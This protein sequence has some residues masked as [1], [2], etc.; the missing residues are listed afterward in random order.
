M[1]EPRP[2][3]SVPAVSSCLESPLVEIAF[4]S[5][6]R[7]DLS[8]SPYVIVGPNAAGLSEWIA[9]ALSQRPR[10]T[11]I[12]IQ[13]LNG[14]DF[15]RAVGFAATTDTLV[16]F[17]ER[18][19]RADVL[20]LEMLEP[21]ADDSVTCRELSSLLDRAT[22]SA[23]GVS[24]QC[25]IVTTL[26]LPNQTAG[27]PASLSSRLLQGLSVSIPIPPRRLKEMRLRKTLA[28]AI[29][30]WDE[31]RID[32][33]LTL[34]CSTLAD[35]DRTLEALSHAQLES[36]DDLQSDF[37][38]P[39]AAATQRPA[40]DAKQLLKIISKLSDLKLSDLKGS[41][42]RRSIVLA[43]SVAIYLLRH[44]T[45]LSLESIGKLFGNRDHTTVLHSFRKITEQRET[46][47]DVQRLIDRV[48]RELNVDPPRIELQNSNDSTLPDS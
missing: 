21:I 15:A 10:E 47:L 28:A 12:N 2:T 34:P 30:R 3:L 7:G 13:F 16:D 42:R 48:C 40:I 17:R 44:L 31:S 38:A 4:Q 1:I 26:R 32:Q 14:K 27:W 46:D 37:F 36:G 8:F 19:D 20:V 29:D 24:H 39:L 5:I 11:S 18:M 6:A 9:L 33:W 35:W 45:D 41:S 22:Q 23:S 25:L 43:R